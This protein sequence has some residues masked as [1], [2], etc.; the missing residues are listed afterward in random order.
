[1]RVRGKTEVLREK[2]VPVQLIKTLR[3]T[4]ILLKD[5]V[6]KNGLFWL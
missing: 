4:R 5:S 1:M 6:R 3:L 2:P